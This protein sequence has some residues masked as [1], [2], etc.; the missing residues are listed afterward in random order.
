MPNEQPAI[1][2]EDPTIGEGSI[3]D[4]ADRAQQPTAYEPPAHEVIEGHDE[5]LD[6]SEE[7]PRRPR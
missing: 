4:A 6:E 1:S 7:L 2:H 3:R 5:W